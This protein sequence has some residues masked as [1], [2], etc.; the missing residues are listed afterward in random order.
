MDSAGQAH[1]GQVDV[2]LDE[3]VQCVS[4]TPTASGQRFTVWMSVDSDKI[5]AP[6]SLAVTNEKR[7][8]HNFYMTLLK[9]L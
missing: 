7:K 4:D 6:N 1:Q 3:M 5:A 9:S 8:W 2:V